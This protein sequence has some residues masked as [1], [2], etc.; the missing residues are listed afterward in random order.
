MFWFF[1]ILNVR[2]SR[3]VLTINSSN[4]Q[5]VVEN[6]DKN[7]VIFLMFHTSTCPACVRATPDFN[8]AALEMKGIAKFGHVL[9]T[10]YERLCYDFNIRAVPSFKIFN[11][12]GVSNFFGIPSTSSFIKSCFSH[13]PDFV[14]TANEKWISQHSNASAVLFGKTWF[15]PP[16]WKA[17]AA[18]VSSTIPNLQFGWT[19]SKKLLRNF[20]V[21]DPPKLIMFKNNTVTSYNNQTIS[22]LRLRNAIIQNFQDYPINPS[23]T[24]DDL[25]NL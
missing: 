16:L 10:S 17:I 5:T 15:M 25:K 22:F 1:S 21:T 24:N 7:S 3:N 8:K 13:F 14:Q 18:N 11:H 2:F 12:K 9:C 19:N 23:D 4:Y 20:N 6:R